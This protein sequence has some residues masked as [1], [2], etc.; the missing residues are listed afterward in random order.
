MN[1]PAVDHQGIL[2]TQAV[3]L[4]W[5]AEA[6][7]PELGDILQVETVKVRP[8]SQVYRIITEQGTS[9]FKICGPDAQ[10][11]VALLAWILPNHAAIAPEIIA[12]SPEQ[13]WILMANAGIPWRD[14]PQP[15]AHHQSLQTLLSRYAQLQQHSLNHIDTLL[16]MPLPDRRLEWLPQ[17][18]RDLIATGDAHGWFNTELPTQVLDTLPSLERLCK[19]LSASPYAAALDHGDLHTGNVLVKSDRPRICDWGDACITHPFCSLLPLVETAMGDQFVSVGEL[20]NSDLIQA[21]LQTWESFTSSH[22]LKVEMQQALCLGLVLRAI[23]IA[24]MLKSADA[25]SVKR[26]SP[27]VSKFLVQWVHLAATIPQTILE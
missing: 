25:E 1:N 2:L 22:V 11:E 18:L 21:Y 12:L 24:Y 14:L 26:W 5:I 16:A 6:L 17:L 3:P 27:Y 13:G 19:C 10:H 20:V 9:Y 15:E 8:W 4:N 7:S 23:D